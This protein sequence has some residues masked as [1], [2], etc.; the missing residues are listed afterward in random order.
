MGYRLAFVV[1]YFYCECICCTWLRSRRYVGSYL[2]QV[3]LQLQ[4]FSE[5]SFLVAFP[6]INLYQ[7][8]VAFAGMLLP[9]VGG[10]AQH[11]ALDAAFV[12]GNGQPHRHAGWITDDK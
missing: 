12:F 10:L 9:A 11:H 6:I 1:G 2:Q 7:I 8:A 4:S 5:Q 3:V